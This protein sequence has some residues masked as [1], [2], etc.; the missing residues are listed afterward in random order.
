MYILFIFT[1]VENL[2]I[3][4][5]IS[6]VSSLHR[7]LEDNKKVVFPLP[8]IVLYLSSLPAVCLNFNWL[9]N[10]VINTE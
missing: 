3:L 5:N 9:F 8:Y 2:N 7:K 4:K 10:L 1:T 6:I